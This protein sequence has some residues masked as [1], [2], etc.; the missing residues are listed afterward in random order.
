MLNAKEA[1]GDLL[2]RYRDNERKLAQS[3]EAFKQIQ[4]QVASLNQMVQHQSG[5]IEVSERY[6]Q[7][8]FG[9]V[10]V[11]R[12]LLESLSATLNNLK[13]LL[14]QKRRMENCLKEQDLA[15]FIQD[16]T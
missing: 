4:E 15:M 11:P 7:A 12:D 6:F 2:T 16:S 8:G 5:S 14:D 3:Q 13:E 9:G 1:V 10:T